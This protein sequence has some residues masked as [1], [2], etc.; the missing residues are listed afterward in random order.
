MKQALTQ[1]V[2]VTVV[3]TLVVL[4]LCMYLLYHFSGIGYGV[5]DIIPWS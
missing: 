3:I 1:S 5:L 2:L 4:A